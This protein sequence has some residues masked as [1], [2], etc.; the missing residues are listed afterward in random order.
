MSERNAFTHVEHRAREADGLQTL[1]R[2]L[3]GGQLILLGI[4]AIIGVGIFVATGP[5]AAHHAGPAVVYSFV[6]AAAACLCAGLCY[7]EFAAMVPVSGSAYSYVYAAFGPI[8]GWM[9]GWCLMLEY[10][11]GAATVAV[12][13]SGYFTGLLHS[14]GIVTSPAL[15]SSPFGVSS[16]GEL[17]LTGGLVNAPAVSLLVLLTAL[18]A[19]GGRVSVWM[20]ALLVGIK[21]CVIGLFIVVGARYVHPANWHPFL[22]A[23]T[24]EFGSFGWSGVFRGAG[25]AFY[26]YLGFDIVSTAARETRHPQRAMPI[27]IIGSLLVCTGVY[28]A[29]S[30]VLTGLAPYR[31]LAAPNPVSV[32]LDHA[33]PRLQL[34]KIAIEIGAVVGLTSSVLVTLYGLSRILYAMSQD[35]LVPRAF[36]RVGVGLS[37]PFAAVFACGSIATLAA[38][39]LPIEVLGELISIGTLSA[40]AFVCSGVLFLRITRPELERPFKT[41]FAPLVCISGVLICAILALGLPATTWRRFLFWTALGAGIY[42][43][44]GRRHRARGT[45][46]RRN[47]VEKPTTRLR[48][49][50]IVE[51]ARAE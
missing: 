5:I 11:M 32:A 4:G 36:S 48:F 13:W 49:S 22:P 46:T 30:L 50:N 14:F 16:V 31:L 42:M 9:V 20:N 47:G 7:A 35:G 24:G 29:F 37:T 43:L 51:D 33:S 28:I 12:A 17:F 3:S 27:G 6:L 38:G 23:N 39:L 26:A 25:V 41:P 44:Y 40:F 45:F 8:A 2:T 1:K 21:L 18:L 19:C 34:L 15:A 10:L